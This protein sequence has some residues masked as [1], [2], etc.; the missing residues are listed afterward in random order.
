MKTVLSNS[1]LNTEINNVVFSNPVNSKT[2]AETEKSELTQLIEALSQMNMN[3]I[4]DV[5]DNSIGKRYSSFSKPEFMKNLNKHFETIKA[6][7]DTQL[8]IINACCG[9]KCY[10]NGD[11]V[12]SYAF[13]SKKANIHFGFIFETSKNNTLLCI[14][15]CRQLRTINKEKLP[16]ESVCINWLSEVYV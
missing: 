7:G 15:E 10:I 6:A 8:E 16:G 12:H 11:F 2:H 13:Y 9:N 5:L 14:N 3:L 4:N 1:N